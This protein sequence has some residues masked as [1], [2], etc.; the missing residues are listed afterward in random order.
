MTKAMEMVAASKMKKAQQNALQG[1][2]YAEKIYEAVNELAKRTARENHPLLFE[3]RKEGK[4][5]GIIISTNK[6]LCGSLNTNL[7]RYIRNWLEE[8][9]DVDFITMGSKGE[10]FVLRAGNNLVADFSEKTLYVEF[11]PPVIKMAVDGFVN[12]EFRQ[13]TIFYNVFINALDQKP[14]KKTILPIIG[15]QDEDSKLESKK[16]SSS[17]AEFK[18]EPDVDQVLSA[19]LPH[20]LENQ[21]RSAVYESE[22]SEHSARMI[23]MKNATDAA[24]DLIDDLTLLYNKA[25]QE[26][27]TYEIAD[28]VTAR[29]AVEV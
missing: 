29:E 9:K 8:E 10:R 15:F 6:G 20:Y 27:I 19:L 3:G 22:A 21:L 24:S 28:M 25:R 7:F 23:A 17:F 13:V 1:K 4:V 16:E 18:I 26:Q 14:A 5:L 12:G 11:V 2:P